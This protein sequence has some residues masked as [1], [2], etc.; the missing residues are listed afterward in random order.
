MRKITLLASMVLGLC[1]CDSVF[2]SY[3]RY[4]AP[5]QDGG[6]DA[7]PPPPLQPFQEPT[8]VETTGLANA[9]LLAVTDLDGDGRPEMIVSRINL[10][11]AI[12]TPFSATSDPLQVYRID[13]T[14]RPILAPEPQAC[15]PLDRV[16]ALQPYRDAKT[17]T[18]YVAVTQANEI[19]FLRFVSGGFDCQPSLAT[20][21]AYT[22]VALG[23][24]TNDQL[25]DVLYYSEVSCGGG[26][27]CMRFHSRKGD[28]PGLAFNDAL[29]IGVSYKSFQARMSYNRT[30]AKAPFVAMASGR[31]DGNFQLNYVSNLLDPFVNFIA[32]SVNFP[33][34]PGGMLAANLDG[35]GYDDVVLLQ[36]AAPVIGTYSLYVLEAKSDPPNAFAP[37]PIKLG[38]F[39]PD[40]PTSYSF[41][42]LR[43]RNLDGV[44]PDEL[45]LGLSEPPLSGTGASSLYF[46]RYS[47]GALQTLAQ[48]DGDGA[49]PALELAELS[50]QGTTRGP[51]DL[52]YLRQRS[53]TTYLTVRR[54]TPGFAW[55]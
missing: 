13:S 6:S 28:M 45:V 32:S 44:G 50:P 31:A 3:L 16:Q 10:D 38:P 7:G 46:L 49:V 20:G 48:L 5:G 21:M 35:S 43:A 40:A 17:G 22:D 47:G 14:G 8:S 9:N 52:I 2:S 25:D 24:M 23:D 55:Q 39:R 29:N 15:G 18:N 1:G 12:R 42:V 27:K 34:Y 26:G 4:G 51:A 41:G 30:E 19:R 11:N 33:L 54:A 36:T 37:L 53:G